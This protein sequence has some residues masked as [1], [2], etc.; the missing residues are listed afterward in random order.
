MKTCRLALILAFVLLG[1]VI[2]AVMPGWFV[3]VVVLFVFARRGYTQL[4][5]HGTARWANL[6]DI[7]KAGMLG[8][9]G[10]ILGRMFTGAPPVLP[11]LFGLLN[12]RTDSTV[13]C[14]R[15]L[16]S[17]QRRKREK[18]SPLIKMNAVH[19]MV[20]APTGVGKGVSI[21]IPHLLNCPESTIVVDFKGENARLT[22]DARR[23]MGH[24]VVILDPFK[25]VGG[26]DTFNPLEFINKDSQL[27]IDECRDLANALVVRTGKE[28]EPHWNDSAEAF[29]TAVI[30]TVVFYGEQGD[31]SLQT[32][33]PLLTN[34]EKLAAVIDLMRASDCASGMLTRLGEQMLHPQEKERGSILSS[35]NRHMRFLDTP[36]ISANTRTSSFDPAELL[37]GKMTVYLVL[38]PEHMRAQ[39]GLLRMWIGSLLRAVVRGGL[40]EKSKVHFVLDEAASLGHLESIDDAVDKYRGYGVRLLFLFQS[41]GQIKTCFPNGMVTL[42]SN[43]SQVFFG[44]NDKETAE[45]VSARL[46]SETIF[47]ENSG[48][49][50]GGS[51]SGQANSASR[52]WGSNKGWSQIKRELLKPEEVAAL[53][54]RVAITFA[55]NTPPIATR[56]SRYYEGER[57]GRPLWRRIEIVIVTIL[58][59]GAAVVLAAKVPTHASPV[60]VTK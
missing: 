11:A 54:P 32:T 4:S 59:L 42:L 52:S 18:L 53:D 46:G 56:L 8:G 3:I 13:A 21:V 25:V 29:I 27:A 1:Y 49:N 15:F 47:V 10:L 43:T 60:W 14:E 48:V 34:P 17:I 57:E 55:P 22:A 2:V 41:L 30:A 36:I 9:N 7:R 44:V 45:Y 31:R 37:T 51:V 26:T 58:L 6:E 40:Q 24:K 12:P 39:A 20:A 28:N 35:A 23:A 50:E 33:R 19:T 38:P 5:A 16:S